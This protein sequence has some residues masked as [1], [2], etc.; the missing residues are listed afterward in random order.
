MAL[1]LRHGRRALELSA[2]GLVGL[3]HF[4]AI[5]GA[6]NTIEKTTHPSN[7]P[8]LMQGSSVRTFAA[9]VCSVVYAAFSSITSLDNLRDHPLTFQLLILF[10]AACYQ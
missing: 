4:S 7:L 10:L 9:Q 5:Y 6:V 8:Q 1:L 2:R 3:I